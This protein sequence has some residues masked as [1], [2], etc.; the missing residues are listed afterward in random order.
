MAAGKS[1]WSSALLALA[2]DGVNRYF[3]R[4]VIALLEIIDADHD[5]LSGIYFLLIPIG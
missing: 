2:G 4:L 3:D 1:S 5:A